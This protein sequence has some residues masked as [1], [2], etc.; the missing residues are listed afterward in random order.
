MQDILT[1]FAQIDIEITTILVRCSVSS[2]ID[3]RVKHPK[4]YIFDVRCFEITV[5]QFSHHSTPMLTRMI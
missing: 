1:H 4:F 5:I 2:A 3:K